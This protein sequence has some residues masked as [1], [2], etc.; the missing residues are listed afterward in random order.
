MDQ[1]GLFLKV[2]SGLLPN[3]WIELKISGC[4][5]HFRA[6]QIELD[7]LGTKNF[8]FGSVIKKLQ[9]FEVGRIFKSPV[10]FLPKK[11]RSEEGNGSAL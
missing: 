5:G 7:N 6:F 4:R 1:P 9:L 11:P 8:Q 10:F 2:A 3:G